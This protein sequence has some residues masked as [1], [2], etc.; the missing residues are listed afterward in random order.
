MTT[1]TAFAAQLLQSRAYVMAH[2]HVHRPQCVAVHSVRTL[3]RCVACTHV[4]ALAAGHCDLSIDSSRPGRRSPS[5]LVTSPR[6]YQEATSR[7]LRTFFQTGER[8]ALPEEEPPRP[9]PTPVCPSREA[10]AATYY[11]RTPGTGSS[12]NRPSPDSSRE[13]TP[14]HPGRHSPGASGFSPAGDGSG[15]G[16]TS[17]HRDKGRMHEWTSTELGWFP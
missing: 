4:R 6:S 10:F 1:G 14:M 3:D 8:I 12:R 13:G 11:A 15:H 16:S 5:S 9:G 17:V 2:E 7:A